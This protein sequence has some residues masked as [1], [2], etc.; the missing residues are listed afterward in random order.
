[1]REFV[2]SSIMENQPM[3]T[4]AVN[5]SLIYPNFEALCSTFINELSDDEYFESLPAGYRFKPTH[6]ELIVHYLMKKINQEMLPRNKINVVNLYEFNPE[7]LAHVYKSSGENEWLFFTPRSKKY[8]NGKRP[9]RAAGNGFWKASGADTLV[10]HNGVDVGSRKTLVYYTGK[11]PKGTKTSWIM[12]EYTVNNPPPVQQSSADDMKLDDWVLCRIRKNEN[13]KRKR[14]DQ[15]Q[16]P[17]NDIYEDEGSWVRNGRQRLIKLL[18]F[19][20]MFG[21]GSHRAG[22]WD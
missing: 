21:I 10:K 15:I 14:D 20:S 8:K 19:T 12:H 5:N 3:Q 16:E 4:N 17:D 22:S 1:M 7:L 9:N 18:G 11:P 2:I 6:D 13:R